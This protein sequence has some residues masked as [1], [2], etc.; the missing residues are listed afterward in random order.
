MNFGYFGVSGNSVY[1]PKNDQ[2]HAENDG[3]VWDF[4][5]AYYTQNTYPL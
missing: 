1:T 2:I 5:V 4:E 3:K